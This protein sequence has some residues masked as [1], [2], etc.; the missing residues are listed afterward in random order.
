MK[1]TQRGPPLLKGN[2][3]FDFE[4]PRKILGRLD[5]PLLLLGNVLQVRLFGLRKDIDRSRE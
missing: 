3:D 1:R 2:G 4:E 5:R